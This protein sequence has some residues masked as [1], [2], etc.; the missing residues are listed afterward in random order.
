M[1]KSNNNQ[2]PRTGSSVARVKHFLVQLCAISSESGFHGYYT[3][4]IVTPTIYSQSV[5]P[6]IHHRRP[7]FFFSF[8]FFLTISRF[9][10]RHEL[11]LNLIGRLPTYLPENRPMGK[12]GQKCYLRNEAMAKTGRNK[13]GWLKLNNYSTTKLR[14]FSSSSSSSE[15]D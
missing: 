11:F 15:A 12:L 2:L 1:K 14:I 4:Y 10:S 7:N 13:F 3:M 6:K 9:L 8:S 5:S